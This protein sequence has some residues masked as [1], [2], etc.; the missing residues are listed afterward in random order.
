[1]TEMPI[2]WVEFLFEL[3]QELASRDF[4]AREQILLSLREKIAISAKNESDHRNELMSGSLV[5]SKL[6]QLLDRPSFDNAWTGGRYVPV[7]GTTLE[8]LVNPVL[9]ESSFY[10]DITLPRPNKKI[11]VDFARKVVDGVTPFES[12]LLGDQVWIFNY[13]KKISLTSNVESSETVESNRLHMGKSSPRMA[14]VAPFVPESWRESASKI[15]HAKVHEKAKEISKFR[16]DNNWADVSPLKMLGYS[17]DVK[18]GLNEGDRREFLLDFCLNMILPRGLPKDY[19]EPW[20][21]PGTKKRILRTAKHLSF[22]RRN[23]AFPQ[24]SRQIMMSKLNWSHANATYEIC[25]RV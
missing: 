16:G 3:H 17:V 5:A 23:L 7:V 9:G 14:A 12:K 10:R 15:R 24:I 13:L 25:R 4:P 20:G 18:E 1:M 22:V 19:V 2:A 8:L 11:M 21:D 6:P